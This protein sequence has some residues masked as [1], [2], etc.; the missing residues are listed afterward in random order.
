M[1]YSLYPH[2]HNIRFTNVTVKGHVTKY[3]LMNII[4]INDSDPASLRTLPMLQ[5]MLVNIMI[6]LWEGP[7][8]NKTDV[9]NQ[10][11]VHHCICHQNIILVIVIILVL[12]KQVR[13]CQST[14]KHTCHQGKHGRYPRCPQLP[15]YEILRIHFPIHKV[16]HP[17]R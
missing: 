15:L 7:F 5:P 17:E 9:L 11:I 6:S 16:C 3:I 12:G 10:A 4:A 13:Q 1:H 8:D 2:Q 14:S